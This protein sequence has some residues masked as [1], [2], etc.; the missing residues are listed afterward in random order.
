ML[1]A[2][3]KCGAR[4]GCPASRARREPQGGRPRRGALGIGLYLEPCSPLSWTFGEPVAED[5]TEYIYIYIRVRSWDAGSPQRVR[6][7]SV[8]CRFSGVKVS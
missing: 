4:A 6:G 2:V 8:A 5:L 1:R 7:W 3:T